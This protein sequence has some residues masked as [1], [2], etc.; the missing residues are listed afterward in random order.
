MGID[1]TVTDQ[2]VQVSTSGQTVNASVS[3]GVGPAGPAGAA[4]PAGPAGAAGAT[5]PQGPAGPAGTTTW[6]GI[7][8]K[9][10]TFA[11][12][13]HAH[14]SITND[15]LIAGNTVSGRFVTTSDGGELVVT[16]ASTGRTLLGLGGAATL[17]VGTAAGTVAAGNDSRLSDARTPTAHTHAAANITD[18]AAAV[19]AVSPE[20]IVEHLT[21]ADFPA[22]GNA[23]LLYIAT[24]S[25]RA[26]RWVGS[27]YAEVGPTSISGGGGGSYTLP[28]AT[29]TT[30]GGVIIGTGLGVSSGT[31]SVTY[32][33][34]AGTACQGNDSRLSD[35]RT[36]TAHAHGNVTNAGAIGSTADR[37]AVTT[38]GG[39]LTT[40]EIGS[41]LT[42]SGGT[43]TASGGGGGGASQALVLTIAALG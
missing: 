26:Y 23:S 10:A 27:Q 30:L 22:T 2:N 21:A 25:S 13:G 39:V 17:N 37:I 35:S 4:G 6:A 9:P 41:G 19:A 33:A 42:L 29:T 43:L 15:G 38:T 34:T 32:G 5:G 24:D 40:A 8:D 14:G 36:P 18:F 11:P 16:G 31:A 20:E 7:A 1:V 3:G 28:N 12:S